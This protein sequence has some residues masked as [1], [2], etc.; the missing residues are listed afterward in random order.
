MVMVKGHFQEVAPWSKVQRDF[1]RNFKYSLCKDGSLTQMT[2][3]GSWDFTL[4]LNPLMMFCLRCDNRPVVDC[5]DN[6]F[7]S[8]QF[9]L[10]IARE[11]LD[12]R[13]H[14]RQTGQRTPRYWKKTLMRFFILTVNF[15][16]PCLISLIGTISGSY[17]LTGS[18]GS[19]ETLV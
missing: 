3:V 7:A 14:Y 15:V 13:S 5:M 6:M 4:K 1:G 9:R 2:R 11:Y 10:A 19:Q 8:S 18:P 16:Q 12:E 17:E